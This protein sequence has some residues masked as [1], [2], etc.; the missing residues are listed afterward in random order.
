MA[1][2]TDTSTR[3]R[4]P[5][6]A[7]RA[8]P[9]AR[10]PRRAGGSRPK[11]HQQEE[12]SAT[13]DRDGF[14]NRPEAVDVVGAIQQMIKGEHRPIS[15]FIHN[16]CALV[17]LFLKKDPAL[18]REVEKQHKRLVQMILDGPPK[19]VMPQDDLPPSFLKADDDVTSDVG[20]VPY[21]GESPGPDRR[22]DSDTQLHGLQDDLP[23]FPVTTGKSQT[24]EEIDTSQDQSQHAPSL[25]YSDQTPP[26][27]NSAQIPT[28]VPGGLVQPAPRPP[29]QMST[30]GG[31][32]HG[33]HPGGRQPLTP[34]GA[35]LPQVSSSNLGQM[36]VPSS[37]GYP[38]SVQSGVGIPGSHQWPGGQTHPPVQLAQASMG[39][40]AAQIPQQWGS[41]LGPIPQPPP[42]PQF[43]Q[44]TNNIASAPGTYQ[45]NLNQGLNGQPA[46]NPQP[47]Q[48]TNN[49]ASTPAAYPQYHSGPNFQPGLNPQQA[50][51][52]PSAPGTYLYN[53]GSNGQ[54]G[55]FHMPTLLQ[56]GASAAESLP[57][58]QDASFV[59]DPYAGMYPSG[60]LI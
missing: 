29:A 22:V 32:Y 19:Q 1:N 55:Q 15:Q 52:M 45:Y 46:P 47:Y 30:T 42:N 27:V 51:N 38:T 8:S 53:Q 25:F 11:S 20:E 23:A 49:V 41:N 36:P 54:P 16:L 43:H 57:H 24:T 14:F 10:R 33:Q 2:K 3:L 21:S 26:T 7:L 34:N 40:T 48:Q 13:L 6:L 56:P 9:P 58:A 28:S 18:G 50:S 39:P 60:S 17:Q 37:A 31:F 35:Q 12:S 44:P 59:G 4:R 5:T